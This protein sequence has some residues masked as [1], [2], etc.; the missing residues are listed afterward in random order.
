MQTLSARSLAEKYNDFHNP[1]LKL[2]MDGR[3]LALGEEACFESARIISSVKREPDMAVLTYLVNRAFPESIKKF[4]DALALG[5]KIE[6]QAGYGSEA[7]RIFFGYLHEVGASDDGMGY[8]IYTLLGLDAKGLMKK[9]SAFL[10][11]GTKKAQQILDEMLKNSGY[12]NFLEKKTVTPIPAEFNQSSIVGGE[13]DYD[14]I[15]NLA[16]RLGYEF[17][18]GRGE[19]IFRAAGQEKSEKLELSGKY[20]LLQ[21]KTIVSMEGQ[22][23]GI[24]VGAYN[25][26]DEKLSARAQWQGV[27]G[28]FTQ[29]LKQKLSAFSRSVWDMGL[30]TGR[31]AELAAGNRMKQVTMQCSR[32][33]ALHMGLPELAPGICIRIVDDAAQSLCGRIYVEEAEHRISAEGYQTYVR[34][35]RC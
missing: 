32:M 30:E 19:L 25:R 22:T 27:S 9:N 6:I 5:E 29:K 33:E 4:E 31:Q 12:S 7:G 35:S 24:V 18:C 20:G 26:A 23:G 1:T 11:S 15:C 3:E 34:G 17:Y 28:P 2:L 21:V 10:A 8:I 13:T 14:W 16:D